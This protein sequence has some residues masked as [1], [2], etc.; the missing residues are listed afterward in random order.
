MKRSA[1]LASIGALSLIA[2]VVLAEDVAPKRPHTFVVGRP[3][4]AVPGITPWRSHATTMPLPTERLHVAWRK[5]IASGGDVI[6]LSDEAGGVWAVDTKGEVSSYDAEGTERQSPIV[7]GL[8]SV[9][10]A[11]FLSDGT[12]VLVSALGEVVG[13]REG[14]LR[15]RT[16]LTTERSS[17]RVPPLAL[18]DG[19]F[20]L[21]MGAE[22][23]ALDAAG[24]VRQ[25][26]SAPAPIDGPL[27][28]GHAAIFGTSASGDLFAW[29]PGTPV[30]LVGAWGGPIDG[31]PAGSGPST[32]VAVLGERLVQFDARNEVVSTLWS[33]PV[34]TLLG[35]PAVASGVSYVV[36]ISPGKT[37]LV[38]I[39]RGTEVMRVR[40]AG[41]GMPLD[42]GG[43]APPV[44]GS[45]LVDLRGHTGFVS[46]DGLFGIASGVQV[47][48][49]QEL[50]CGRPGVATALVPSR[51]GRAIYVGCGNGVLARIEGNP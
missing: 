34:G 38:G 33:A 36:H 15:F 19:G 41:A 31:G 9:H 17:R 25:R 37:E 28:S 5:S 1:A 24:Q 43:W 13:V 2:W 23:F 26:A 21:A 14:T 50:P 7:T 35:P 18:E 11:T 8:G 16:R 6:P 32:M 39:G 12:I 49:A 46:A 40:I 48:F 22:F 51:V 44:H 20:A 29:K 30:R 47:A 27:V 3:P 4:G 45:L 42:A 10:G